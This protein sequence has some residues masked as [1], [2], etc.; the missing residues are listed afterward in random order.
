MATQPKAMGWLVLPCRVI[1]GGLFVFA[2]VMKLLK[3][4]DFAQAIE[5][6]KLMPEKAEHLTVLATFVMPWLEII[7]GGFLVI[8]LWARSAALVISAL[9][10]VFIGMIASVLVR[11]LDVNCGCFGKFEYP[12]TGP[13]GWCQIIRDLVMLGMGAVVVAW[14]P[15]PLAIDRESTK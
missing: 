10:V 3:P 13:M 11:G 9:L 12:C 2:G 4:M 5:A 1:L 6:F 15:G 14:G 8:G 7:T